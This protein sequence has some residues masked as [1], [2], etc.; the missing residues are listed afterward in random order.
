ME[1]YFKF[2]SIVLDAKFGILALL[3]FRLASR[4]S[5]LERFESVWCPKT[6]F[7]TKRFRNSWILGESVGVRW[8]VRVLSFNGFQGILKDSNGF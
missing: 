6:C 2:I 8:I 4:K 3:S 7:L 1:V 5:I